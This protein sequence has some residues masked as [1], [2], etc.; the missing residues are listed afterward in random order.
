MNYVIDLDKDFSLKIGG[1]E[2]KVFFVSPADPRLNLDDVVRKD[3]LS[4]HGI[5]NGERY[6]IYINNNDPYTVKL[7]TLIHEITH[8]LEDFYQIKISHRDI[9]LIG[10]IFSQIL[11]DNFSNKNNI[12]NK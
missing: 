1:H 8:S 12:S 2:I 11:I 3:A 6:E 4:N 10:E 9:N 5:Y 7:S